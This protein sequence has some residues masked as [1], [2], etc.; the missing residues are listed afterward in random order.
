MDTLTPVD[1]ITNMVILIAC[2]PVLAMALLFTLGFGPFILVT[3]GHPRPK[4]GSRLMLAAASVTALSTAL[5][6]GI[7]AVT[8]PCTHTPTYE[9]AAWASLTG[10]PATNVIYAP[11]YT[12]TPVSPRGPP[13]NYVVST[14]TT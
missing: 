7:Y 8:R 9:L 2:L 3:A 6:A 11:S 13:D 5:Y 10:F 14:V 1:I 4:S 12:A